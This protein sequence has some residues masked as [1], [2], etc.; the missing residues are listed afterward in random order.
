MTIGRELPSDLRAAYG[1]EDRS[2]TAVRVNFIASIDGATARSGASGA[3]GNDDDKRVFDALRSLC[4]VILVG[5]GTVAVE[6]YGGVRVSDADVRWRVEHGLA[7]QPPVAVVSASLSLEPSHPVFHEAVVR[8]LVVTCGSSDAGRREAL[9]EVA[10]VLVCGDDEVDPNSMLA[11][12]F[13]RGLTQV[14]CEGGPT[15]LGTLVDTDLVDELCLT[16]S[17]VLE[18]GDSGR[19]ATGAD[20]VSRAMTLVHAIPAGDLLFLRYRRER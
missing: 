4:D 18:G 9:S 12:L 2:R 14:L 10:D 15:L 13:E 11:A 3:L 1:L 16:L 8:P 6:G 19:I 20:V 17:P 7:A 5:A